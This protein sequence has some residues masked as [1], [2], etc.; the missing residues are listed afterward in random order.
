MQFNDEID[1]QSI[2]AK[3]NAHYEKKELTELESQEFGSVAS[4]D[5]TPLKTDANNIKSLAAKEY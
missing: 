4:V 2:E 1:T 3:V 5:V